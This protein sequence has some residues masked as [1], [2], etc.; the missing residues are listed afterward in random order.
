M[1]PAQIIYQ[2]LLAV[3]E[4]AAQTGKVSE[5]C[6]VLGISRT[7][8]YRLPSA[9]DRRPWAEVGFGPL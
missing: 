5:T 3:L 4:H 9:A 6:R 8:Y 2:R 7:R 1:I